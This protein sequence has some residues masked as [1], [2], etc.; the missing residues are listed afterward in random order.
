MTTF[1]HLQNTSAARSAALLPG[2]LLSM[3]V[4]V[5]AQKLAGLPALHD[6]GLSALPLSILLGLLIGNLF[7]ARFRALEA[8][9]QAGVAFAKGYC[10]RLGVVLFGFHITLQEIAAVGVGG[11]ALALVMLTSTFALTVFVGTRWLKL[12]RSTCV[13]IGA[14]ASICGAAAVLATAPIVRARAEQVAVAIA[15]V[16]LFGTLA[17]FLYPALFGSLNLPENVYGQLVGATVHEVAQV[18][19]A[20]E[21]VGREAL[22]AAVI[23][24]M[25]RVLLLAPF[26]LMLSGYWV[27]TAAADNLHTRPRVS[28]PW[29]ALGFI[30]IA[31]LNSLH[32]LP[33]ATV[34]AILKLDA[35]LLAT[36][37]AAL[38]L[39]MQFASVFQAGWRA[40]LLAA[41]ATL[42]LM[43]AGYGSSLWWLT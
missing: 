14:G 31:A 42:F 37:M 4:A 15:S 24:K 23:E 3:T 22:R 43:G 36:A 29:F 20:G 2:L 21:A 18:V 35:A 30:L 1:F 32:G 7:P 25:L 13:L 26:L 19:V 33:T 27:R 6:S 34:Q 28:I 16:V 40:L 38:G 5:I 12:E 39:S 9:S 10:L 17:M 11:V 8:N 41:I